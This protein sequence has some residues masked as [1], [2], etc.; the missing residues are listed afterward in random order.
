MVNGVGVCAHAVVLGVEEAK[1]AEVDEE[2]E[3]STTGRIPAPGCAL[4]VAS[5]TLLQQQV[6]LQSGLAAIVTGDLQTIK[7]HSKLRHYFRWFHK[8]CTKLKSV[9][10]DFSCGQVHK[11]CLSS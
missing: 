8:F 7:A 10:D 4:S 5:M 3:V 11:V 6:P 9:G 2:R 1:V